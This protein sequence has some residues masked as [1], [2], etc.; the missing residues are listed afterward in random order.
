[1]PLNLNIIVV[2]TGTT[3]GVVGV[4]ALVSNIPKKSLKPPKIIPSIQKEILFPGNFL[5]TSFVRKS[6]YPPY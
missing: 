3:W 2:M 6:N 4:V 1:M 5:K